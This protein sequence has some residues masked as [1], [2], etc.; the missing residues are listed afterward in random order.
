MDGGGPL[1][2]LD[3]AVYFMVGQDVEESMGLCR[4]KFWAGRHVRWCCK[5]SWC[6]WQAEKVVSNSGLAP[7][8]LGMTVDELT[9]PLARKEPD[10]W[11]VLPVVLT[12]VIFYILSFKT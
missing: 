6:K 7:A 9:L 3:F 10:G 12:F 8:T 5:S 2:I 11:H 4:R 1:E